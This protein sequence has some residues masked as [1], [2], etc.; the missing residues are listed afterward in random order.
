MTLRLESL[1]E[2]PKLPE[3]YDLLRG[4]ADNIMTIGDFAGS[5]LE[6]HDCG[7][8]FT[9]K[10]AKCECPSCSRVF[11]LK[12]ESRHRKPSTAPIDGFEGIVRLTTKARGLEKPG[13]KKNRHWFAANEN[14]SV[15]E[16]VHQ[17]HRA[18]PERTLPKW[19]RELGVPLPADASLESFLMWPRFP[20][21]EKKTIQPDVALAFDSHVVLFE[22]KRPRGGKTPGVEVLGQLAFAADAALKLDRDWHIV[23]VPSGKAEMAKTP[24]AWAEKAVASTDATLANWPGRADIIRKVS[25]MGATELATRVTATNWQTAING[26]EKAVTSELPASWTGERVLSQLAFLLKSQQELFDGS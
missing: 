19:L 20:F 1:L 9:T 6:C 18:Q 26:F 23:L 4:L 15:A 13:A 17:I 14:W 7:F 3:R 25:A 21:G 10:G 8:T 22:F 16:F 2:D 11:E 24:T 12:F 5:F